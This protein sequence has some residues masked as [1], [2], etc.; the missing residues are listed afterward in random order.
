MAE[1]I[2]IQKAI[3]HAG[4]RSRRKAAEA[5]ELGRVRLA[6][7]PTRPGHRLDVERQGLTPDGGPLPVNPEIESHL[8]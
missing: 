3:A 1:R 4:L 8:L 5:V 6:R 2:R 7:A